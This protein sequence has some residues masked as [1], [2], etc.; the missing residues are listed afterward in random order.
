MSTRISVTL[1][2]LSLAVSGC[3][4]AGTPYRADVRYGIYDDYGEPFIGYVG[5]APY[6]YYGGSAWDY[7]DYY[8]HFYGPTFVVPAPPRVGAR[9]AP[10]PPTIV[11]ARIP[12]RA[13]VAMRVPVAAHGG[14]AY[15][16]HGHG[17]HGRR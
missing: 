3:M 2:V 12:G 5:D 1:V 13:P 8:R 16:G 4:L 7:D 11:G 17:R 15:G 10:P 9:L 14:P 6:V